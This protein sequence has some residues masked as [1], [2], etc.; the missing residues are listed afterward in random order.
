MVS[1]TVMMS[2]I[3]CELVASSC[4]SWMLCSTS[5]PPLSAVRAAEAARRLACSV[6]SLFC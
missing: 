1:M 4:I 2:L 5:L 6:D 3:F